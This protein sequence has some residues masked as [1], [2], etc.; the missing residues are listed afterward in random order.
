MDT[1]GRVKHRCAIWALHSPL[2]VLNQMVHNCIQC[3]RTGVSRS[4]FFSWR[5]TTSHVKLRM[6][7]VG[8]RKKNEANVNNGYVCLLEQFSLSLFCGRDVEPV[9]IPGLTLKL[10]KIFI[11]VPL[12]VSPFF[13]VL[14]PWEGGRG[15]ISP[16]HSLPPYNCRQAVVAASRYG[17]GQVDS[18]YCR[19]GT[20]RPTYLPI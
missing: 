11:S 17:D 15:E 2:P 20:G 10:S 9:A 6:E 19:W 13:A 14:R 16:Y 3:Q 18:L 8:S 4:S 12:H 7:S 5:I 1:N